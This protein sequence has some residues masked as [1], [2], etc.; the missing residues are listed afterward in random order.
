MEQV[1]TKNRSPDTDTDSALLYFYRQQLTEQ[2]EF[3]RKRAE[4]QR[5]DEAKTD[6]NRA[7][8]EK[9]K[10]AALK[11]QAAAKGKDPTTALAAGSSS[12][13]GE[14]EAKRQR[15]H[16]DAVQ[17]IEFKPKDDSDDEHSTQDS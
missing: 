11:A 1:N 7:K 2:E 8:R 13:D 5:K 16:N 12:K 17:R 3:D 6:K 9:K 4:V 14:P 15:L 10:L